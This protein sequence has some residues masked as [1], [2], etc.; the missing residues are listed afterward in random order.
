MRNLIKILLCS[1][2][3]SLA[4]VSC[5]NNDLDDPIIG[6]GFSMAPVVVQNSL[7]YYWYAVD[8]AASYTFQISD[9]EEFENYTPFED[10]T[11][12]QIRVTDL[13]YETVYYGRMRVNYTNGNVSDWF[14]AEPVTTY[15]YIDVPIPEVLTV[16]GVVG[17][18]VTFSVDTK[19]NVDSISVTSV[20]TQD[21]IAQG[22]TPEEIFINIKE[23]G[24]WEQLEEEGYFMTSLDFF[25]PRTNYVAKIWNSEY[26]VAYNE[27]PF[28]TSVYFDPASD[29]II[30]PLD[31]SIRSIFDYMDNTREVKIYLPADYNEDDEFEVYSDSISVEVLN[32]NAKKLYIASEDPEN[33][34]TLYISASMNIAEAMDELIFEDI[35]FIGDIDVDGYRLIQLTTAVTTG[36]IEFRNCTF[37]NLW[38]GIVGFNNLANL[39][40]GEINFYNCYITATDDCPTPF[41]SDGV[42]GSGVPGADAGTSAADVGSA[43]FENCTFYN[44]RTPLIGWNRSGDSAG[45]NVSDFKGYVINC[46]F[47]GFDEIASNLIRFRNDVTYAMYIANTVFADREGI[48]SY[49]KNWFVGGTIAE[50]FHTT[51]CFATSKI[52]NGG[53]NMAFSTIG[54]EKSTFTGIQLFPEQA[55]QNFSMASGLT[56]EGHDVSTWGVGDARWFHDGVTAADYSFD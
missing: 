21:Q 3:G 18:V 30:L 53:T 43:R 9:D 51:N 16:E 8:G 13:E 54:I 41:N 26:K 48:E 2:F 29:E 28:R 37:T 6:T 27:V 19:Y 52:H 22:V 49:S 10:L 36:K 33:R 40:V 38:R 39:Y 14:Y 5:E 25:Q 47:C 42:L 24:I 56:F 11:A 4:F 15:E 23:D 35:D 55:E 46:T 12:T 32:I 20:L 31:Q 7:E 34:A 44:M 45:L 50:N 1:V 17:T